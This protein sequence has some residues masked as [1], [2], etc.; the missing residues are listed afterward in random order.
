MS[1][2]SKT[3]TST[4]TTITVTSTTNTTNYYGNNG[5]PC[6]TC[7]S[8]VDSFINSGIILGGGGLPL[9][10][11][12]HAF[13]NNSGITITS[14]INYL[15]AFLG[16]GGGGCG[17]G[18]FGGAGG[19]GGGGTGSGTGNGISTGGSIINSTTNAS[20]P[21][22]GQTGGGGGGPGGNGAYAYDDKTSSKYSDY[23]YSTGS[24]CPGGNAG[25]ITNSSG[26][27]AGI[28]AGINIYGFTYGGGG[29]ASIITAT[30]PSV[31]TNPGYY[32]GSSGGGGYG[33]GNANLT[34]NSKNVAFGGG[35]GGG[36]GYGST[37]FYNNTGGN[38]GYS[39]YNNGIITTFA[40][41]QGGTNYLYGPCFY[42]GNAPTNYNI[43]IQSVSRYGQLFCT[44]CSSTTGTI[45]FGIDPTSIITDSLS[46][47]YVLVGITPINL[48]GI[49]NG[50]YWNLIYLS[51]TNS[52]FGVYAYH[53]YISPYSLNNSLNK[54]NLLSSNALNTSYYRHVALT[55]SG[56]THTLY[57]D[58]SAVATNTNAL[59]IFQYY[60]S[61]ISKLLIGSAADLTN[62]YS[63]YIDD[64]KVFNRA[65]LASD[66]SSIYYNLPAP[67]VPS[68]LALVGTPTYNSA[69]ISFT[70]VAVTNITKYS[71][72][73]SPSA[74]TTV[75]GNN[76]N[77]TISGL[78]DNT[79]YNVK[80]VASNSNE[81]TISTSSLTF[82]T[83]YLTSILD[84]LSSTTKSNLI[85]SGTTLSAGAYGTRLLYGRY[86]GFIMT[87]RRSSDNTIQ[88]FYADIS[89]NLGT[90]FF[91]G[92]TSLTTW[93]GTSYAYVT[94][95]WDQTGNGNHAIQTNISAQ[96][97]YNISGKYIDFGTTTTGG[98][99]NAYFNLPDGTHPYGDSEY[100]YVFRYSSTST[101]EHALFS[102][103]T[104][105]NINNLGYFHS[106]H[107]INSWYG[108]DMI[109]TTPYIANTNTII[110]VKFSKSST[111]TRTLY[112]NGS[113]VP[114]ELYING[115]LIGNN[116]S[117][118]LRTQTNTN[119]LLGAEIF[120][121]KLNGPLYYAYIVPIAI[122]EVDRDI[123]EATPI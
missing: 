43:Y 81:T 2:D 11:G 121:N 118:Q 29:G 61:T 33:G 30:N 71:V 74:T 17:A 119:N 68:N 116:I 5:I 16:G 122:S 12:Q 66:I 59:N 103:G 6:F 21:T 92:G 93:L 110:S 106:I 96:P 51:A 67:S 76:T 49:M 8:N 114:T 62:G 45:T 77:L 18:N 28:N 78:S 101:T 107:Y 83:S 56:N 32:G 120:G 72:I 88:N 115:V 82:T 60:P 54:S 22:A 37:S 55:I 25:I 69:S 19:G 52:I 58:G 75:T 95:W 80:I 105:L 10:A 73:L 14:F 123:L 9:S 34:A 112:I 7:S 48:S 39:I 90:T 24:G 91:G 70:M 85:Y 65:L 41:G 47:N 79:T 111:R 1:A 57:L 4:S 63:G 108:N 84:S 27:Y 35:G 38:G 3:Y 97:I 13:I 15:G 31:F 44:G 104:S 26:F 117:S 98:N 99:A 89:G 23:V 53:L 86:K 40:N 46:L 113:S 87:I 102:G 100:S 64:F 20:N 50:F 109:Y 42:A 94:Q 36:G